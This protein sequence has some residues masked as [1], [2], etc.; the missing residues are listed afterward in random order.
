MVISSI[1]SYAFIM[2]VLYICA[3]AASRKYTVSVRRGVMNPSFITPEVFFFIAFFT[4]VFAIRYNVGVDYAGYLE[5][6]ESGYKLEY[7]KNEFLFQQIAL[8]CYNLNFHPTIYFGIFVVIQITFFLLSFKN[9]KF[10]YPFFVIFLF[11][12]GEANQWMNIIR[13]AT[14]MCIWLYSIKF[15]EKKQ[16]WKYLIFVLIAAGFH[17]SALLYV[18]LYPLLTFKEVKRPSIAIQ[19]II[20]AAAFL[21]RELF[22][23]FAS[24]LIP[25]VGFV[26]SLLGGE[27]DYYKNYDFATMMEDLNKGVSGTGVA[28]FV[29]L[30]I[31]IVIISYSNKL[32]NFY[33]SR[34]FNILYVLFIIALFFFYCF[35]AAVISFSRPFRFFFVLRTVML[36]Y[37]AYYL[38]KNRRNAQNQIILFLTVFIYLGLFAFAQI[39]CNADTCLWYQTWFNQ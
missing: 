21:I 32:H 3:S 1:L 29:K 28:F 2:I 6:Y 7:S 15:I 31:D 17:R 36:A 5:N 30:V 20:L 34:K 4:F 39:V 16:F 18:I 12:N 26:Q 11:C 23:I 24:S 37:F 33:N 22:T 25:V 38:W 8:F 27:N 13:S 10:L 35:P 19:F 14:A 9:E